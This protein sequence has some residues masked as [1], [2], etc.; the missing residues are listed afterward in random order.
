MAD[1]DQKQPFIFDKDPNQVNPGTEFDEESQKLDVHRTK[2]RWLVL[3]L[4]CM[5]CLGSYYC[6]DNPSAL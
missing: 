6:Y 4:S 5:L 1:D 2:K 3:F